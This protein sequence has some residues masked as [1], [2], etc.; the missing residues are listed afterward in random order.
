MDLPY[1]EVG[2]ERPHSPS[3]PDPAHGCGFALSAPAERSVQ[4]APGADVGSW[5]PYTP[6]TV[7]WAPYFIY[8]ICFQLSNNILSA[9]RIHQHYY[10][11]SLAQISFCYL[12][13]EKMKRY[14]GGVGAMMTQ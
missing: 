5:H 14:I 11:V 2:E 4:T 8:S 3:G 12:L 7:H 13:L 10:E 1:R 6:H 9:I